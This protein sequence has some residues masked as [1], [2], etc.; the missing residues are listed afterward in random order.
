MFSNAMAKRH[1]KEMNAFVILTARMLRLERN[2]RVFDKVAVIP[3]ELIRKIN[4][5]FLLW[6]QAKLCGGGHEPKIT[7]FFRCCSCR[8]GSKDPISANGDTQF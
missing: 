8:G 3:M 5:E 1:D 4:A 7:S 6:K 2:A